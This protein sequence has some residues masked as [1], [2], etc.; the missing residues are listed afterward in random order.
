MLLGLRITN[1]ILIE[2]AHLEFDEGFTVFTGE[3]GAGKSLLIKALTLLLGEKGG[4]NYIKPGKE[5]A[6]IEA[7]FWGGEGLAKKLEAMGY[8][9]EE[10]IHVKRVLSYQRQRCYLN[11]SP[12]TLAEL[13]QITSDLLSITSQHEH[14]FFL[15]KDNQLALLDSFLG[16]NHLLS[17]YKKLYDEYKNLD[18]KI[19][20]LKERLGQNLLKRDFLL[21]QIKEIE[22]LNPKLE[23]EEELLRL[24]DRLKHLNL[25]RELAHSIEKASEEVSLYLVN[26]LKLVQKLLSFEPSLQDRYKIIQDLYYELKELHGEIRGL[27]T[28]LPEDER[29]LEEIEA[30]LARYERIKKKYA[31]STAELVKL[32]ENLKE[33]LNLLDT[34][35]EE[36][37]T[38][39]TKKRNLEEVLIKLALKIRE[40]RLKGKGDFRD[41]IK[42]ELKHLAMERAEFDVDVKER[43]IKA[44][45]LTSTGL[46]EVEF[47]FTS[48]PGVPPRTLDKV[49]SGGELSRIFLA[50]KIISFDYDRGSTLIFDEV[51]SGI[52]GLTALKVGEKLKTLSTR[53][54]VIC[55]THLPQIARFADHHFL[56]EKI[57]SSQ[58]TE[59]LIRKLHGEERVK[60]LA[61]MLGDEDNLEIARRFYNG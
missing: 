49:V 23:E 31:C 6:Q 48:N 2:E 46:D 21:F 3:T 61:R 52:G 56:V 24:R 54:Q 20:D 41:R 25:I 60:E 13:S 59:T 35:E 9:S 10:E 30:R 26:M 12:I 55:I 58:Q 1:F 57:Y 44:E 14:Y 47:L 15:K 7:I 11:G 37:S 29:G 16:L 32:K 17:E 22:D 43:E 18:H 28:D 50:F 38:L 53:T 33:E 40:A 45:N 51:D 34:S 8:P 5:S 36:L 19:K 27:Y 42:A 39:E 4:P